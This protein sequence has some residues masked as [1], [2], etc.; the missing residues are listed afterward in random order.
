[1]TLFLSR[2]RRAPLS[3]TPKSADGGPGMCVNSGLLVM[4]TAAD[5]G[6]WVHEVLTSST[7]VL[8]LLALLVQSTNTDT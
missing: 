7:Q 8:T 3:E 5:V 6:E 2:S 1:M 4:E